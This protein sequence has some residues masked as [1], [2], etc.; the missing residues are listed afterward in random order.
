MFSDQILDPSV[1]IIISN[2]LPTVLFICS[3][4]V[5]VLPQ[6]PRHIPY[7]NLPSRN[8]R[9]CSSFGPASQLLLPPLLFCLHSTES[10]RAT[11]KLPLTSSLSDALD[12]LLPIWRSVTSKHVSIHANLLV[13]NRVWVRILMLMAE[14]GY[15]D[16]LPHTHIYSSLMT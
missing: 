3:W 4:F 13:N 10:Q 5:C 15:W 6:K 9:K 7:L 8:S 14:G 1:S 2:L 16:I 12:G 11:S